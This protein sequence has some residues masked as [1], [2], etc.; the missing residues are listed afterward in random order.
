M[1]WLK[2][3][4]KHDTSP[5][6]IKVG[7]EY[8]GRI[9][10][11]INATGQHGLIAS[12]THLPKKTNWDAAKDACEKLVL[13]GY[14]DWFIPKIE[15]LNQLYIHKDVIG[16]FDDESYYRSSSESSYDCAWEQH[17]GNGNQITINKPFTS[18]IRVVRIF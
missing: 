15:Q 4:L 2:N 1:S 9:V 17:F 11:Y 12:K 3:I 5:Q 7:D 10:A 8:A 14:S 6:H 18:R 13:N 16:G